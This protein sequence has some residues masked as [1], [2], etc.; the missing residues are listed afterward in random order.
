MPIMRAGSDIIH[1]QLPVTH[2]KGIKGE[3]P[4]LG[5]SP[6][7]KL[8]SVWLTPILRAMQMMGSWEEASTLDTNPHNFQAHLKE[9]PCRMNDELKIAMVRMGSGT[10]NILPTGGGIAVPFCI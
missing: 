9:H 8:Y 5:T 2:N 7:L 1:Y 6:R 3:I 4:L 10:E